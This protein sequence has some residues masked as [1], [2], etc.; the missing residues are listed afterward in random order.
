MLDLEVSVTEEMINNFYCFI[1]QEKPEYSPLNEERSFDYILSNLTNYFYDLIDKNK[2]SINF[3]E[4]TLDSF[5]IHLRERIYELIRQSVIVF[6]NELRLNNKLNYKDTHQQYSYFMKN[7]FN[8]KGLYK[9]FFAEYPFLL[10]RL[11]ISIHN[12]ILFLK[13]LSKQLFNDK[14][15]LF[16]YYGFNLEKLVEAKSVGDIHNKSK[17]TMILKDLENK[18]I[19][20]KPVNFKNSKLYH[21]L[22]EEFNQ[23]LDGVDI[24]NPKI[25]DRDLYG[26]VEFI[27]NEDCTTLKEVKDYYYNSGVVLFVSYMLNGNDLH[28]ENIIACRKSPIVIDYETLGGDIDHNVDLSFADKLLRK[29]VMNSRLLPIRFGKEKSINDFSGLGILMRKK[30]KII[31]LDNE[32]TSE[33]RETVKYNITDDI[34]THLPKIKDEI[35]TFDNFKGE[36]IRGF[37]DA[38]LFALGNKKTILSTIQQKASSFY[39]RKVYRNTATY[40]SLLE[41]MNAPDLMKNKEYTKQ[42][43]MKLLSKDTQRIHP[44]EHLESEIQQLI[45]GAIPYFLKHNLNKTHEDDINIINKI[46]LLTYSDFLLQIKLMNMS[47]LNSEEKFDI[48][49]YEVTNVNR[50]N[51]NR[52][53]YQSIKQKIEGII[54][55]SMYVSDLEE[56]NFIALKV[57]WQ[58]NLEI[59]TLNNGVYDGVLGL[60][61]TLNNNKYIKEYLNSIEQYCISSSLLQHHNNVGVING[62]NSLITYHLGYPENKNINF[63]FILSMLTEIERRIINNEYKEPVF[64]FIGGTAGL[65]VTISELYK[66]NPK[67]RK[68]KNIME[69]LGDYLISS[70]KEKED[71]I[72]WYSYGNMK[73]EDSLKGI[74]HGTT[75]YLLALMTLKDA[76]KTNKYDSWI[77][78]LIDIEKK[79]VELFDYSNSWCKGYVGLGMS[80]LKM[81][82]YKEDTLPI[83]DELTLYKDHV[84]NGLENE[85][86]YCL[87]HGL[88]GSYDFL[89]EL[90]RKNLLNNEDVVSMNKSMDN[91]FENLDLSNYNPHKISLF[92]GLG[93]ILYFI[94]R[95]ENTDQRSILLFNS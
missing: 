51:I 72:Y 63:R 56:A 47:L 84:I 31:S 43:L 46:H 55:N 20:F 27:S 24:Y 22:I 44:K 90:N 3:N 57:N 14:D 37:S 41:R 88:M 83:F 91:Y 69:H 67:Y 15:I 79:T 71:Y 52:V 38:Y 10:E 19:I 5:A 42:F 40:R 36:I 65:I 4:K 26:Y 6:L 86:D 93:S 48:K 94:N 39:Y 61:L 34:C 92:T 1:E 76:L 54:L 33:I 28:N 13:W 21:S 45:E 9:E 87:C 62:V 53:N 2:E 81:L 18:K 82:A 29:S 60:A 74:S 59:N 58:G 30:V 66:N 23:N 70:V 8:E 75:G 7:F 89:L 78:K 77:F 16:S 68:L 25:V 49:Q 73:M 64:D 11:L 17:R 80:R 85:N 50:V 35:F 95:L 32:F 12:E